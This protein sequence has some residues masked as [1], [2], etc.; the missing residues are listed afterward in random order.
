VASGKR[1]GK[2]GDSDNWGPVQTLVILGVGRAGTNCTRCSGPLLT[3][4]CGG[5]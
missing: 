1:G 5:E 4:L 2:S 3:W